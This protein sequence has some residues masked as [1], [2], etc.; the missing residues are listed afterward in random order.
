MSN[1]VC[2]MKKNMK[3]NLRILLLPLFFIAVYNG[4]SQVNIQWEARLDGDGS[5]IDKV[6]DMELD[7]AGNTY[8]TGSSYNGSSYDIV[9]VKYDP[10][11]VEVWRSSYGGAGID[12]G[13]AIALDSD[14]DVLVTGT[15]FISGSDWDVTILKYDG[16]TGAELWDAILG[17]STEYDTGVDIAVDGSDNVIVLGRRKGGAPGDVDFVTLKYTSAGAFTWARFLGGTGNDLAKVLLVDES[18]NIYVGGHREFSEGSTYFDFY[19]GK[20]NAAGT[21]QWAVSEDSDYGKLD[22]PHA[23]ALDGS[24]NIILA[25]SGFTDILNEEDFLTMKF[26]NATG[27]LMWKSLYAGNAEALDVIYAV[28]VDDSDNIY[29]TG[30]SKS[31]ETSEDFYTIAYNSGGTELW[32]DRYST[33]GLEYDEA[34]DIR[35]SDSDLNVYVTGYS[36]D[37]ASNNDFTTIKYDIATGD[38]EWVTV[39]DG[40]SSLSDQALVMR[41]DPVDNIFISGNSHGGVTN[42]DYSTIK[43]CQL[44]TAASPDT[45][46]CIG[47]SVDLTA[48]GGT[49]VTWE[50]L[51]GDLGSMSCTLCET[52]TA[53]PDETT[54]YIVSSESLSGCID[55]DTVLVVVNDIPTVSI[56]N[57]TPLDFCLGDSV[58]LYTDTYDSYDWSTGSTDI[59]TIVYEAGDVDLTIVDE[60]GCSNTA[61]VTVSTFAGPDVDAGLDVTICPGETTGLLATGADEYLWNADPTL[62]GLLI[63]DPDATPIVETEYV[64]TGTD[65]DGCQDRDTVIVSLFT[66]PTVDAGPNESV[67]IGDSIHLNATGATDY[68]WDAHPSLSELDIAD[69]WATPTVLTKYFVT[70][71]D[72]N[73]CTN[74][75]SVTISTLATPDISAG[76]D[77]AV[78]IGGSVELSAT[79]GLP[80]EYIWNDDPTLSELD[81]PNPDATP[82]TGTF[83]IV[84]GTDINGCKNTDTVFVD[85]YDL[86][87]VDAG[88]DETICIGDSTHLEASG[89]TIY[90]WDS[91]PTLSAL[92][93][94]DPW[95]NPITTRTY[96]VTAEDDNG[97]VNTD[98]VTIT[99]SPLPDID[100]GP[101]V[102]VC[103]GDSIQLNAT[104]GVLFVW[105][106]DPTLSNFVIGDPWASPLIETTYYLE[107]TDEFGC[108]NTDEVTVSVNPIPAPPVLTLLDTFIVSSIEVG[109]QWHHETAGEL[110]G[111]TNDSLNYVDIGLNGEY[112][113]VYTDENGCSVTSDRV[114]NQIIVTGLSIQELD[115]ELLLNVY[116]NPSNGLIN[117]ETD[118]DIDQLVVYSL[119]GQVVYQLQD[120]GN[121]IVQVDLSDLADGNYILRVV[122]GDQQ[123]TRQLIK[124]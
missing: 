95:A 9:T 39:F 59:S 107:G 66:E 56:Y 63:A 25:G 38:R 74:R 48:S 120:M 81:I 124:L 6:V 33:E 86:P 3:M 103:F 51:E 28:D 97:C 78:C 67:C 4:Y 5:F 112:W 76:P 119:D 82:T 44:T 49:D 123:T 43:Y 8:L 108:S 50:V 11:G 12:E 15:T 30:K 98:D 96:T 19:L 102:A 70:G 104:G 36:F 27:A 40:P 35:V 32:S 99:V 88:P 101:D 21:L 34:T 91:D 64:V 83:Y 116:P 117:I 41:I 37:P 52:M 80:D 111:E 93:I 100:A 47:E 58:E 110:V 68:A 121:G 26:D 55:Y 113:S 79:G 118:S 71:T 69:P 84:E 13:Q 115:D 85:V 77:D 24:N 31:S 57:D 18:D 2:F 122:S 23:M 53:T 45:S 109:N 75:D 114:E 29:V 89:G 90:T 54:T 10:D 106:F 61:S 92:D 65:G 73:G 1:L 105:E 42:L 62:S 46:V 20:Y 7:A 87:T 16:D 22:T 94:S 72:D 60:N 17:G 14:G